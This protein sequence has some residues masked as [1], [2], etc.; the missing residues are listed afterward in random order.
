MLG[1]QRLVDIGR[2]ATLP[3]EAQ[4]GLGG[5]GAIRRCGRGAGVVANVHLAPREAPAALSGA[6]PRNPGRLN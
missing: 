5:W 2:R 4:A 6:A 3:V 1:R